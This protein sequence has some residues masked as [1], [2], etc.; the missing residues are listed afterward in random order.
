[1]IPLAPGRF[2]GLTRIGS[3]LFMFVVV[4]PMA[5][6]ACRHPFGEHHLQGAALGTGYHITLYADLD[7]ASL[8]ALET[9]I[10]GELERL[11]RK[12]GLYVRALN[13]A[14]ARVGMPAP[15]VLLGEMDRVVHALA[16]DR[17]TEW[18]DAHEEI[19]A[20]VEMGGVMRA[21]G[22]PPDGGWR[23]SLERA[24]L[25]KRVEERYLYLH[26]AALVHRFTELE[27]S[28][29]IS[30]P[31]PLG[32]SVVADTASEAMRQA[33]R[34]MLARPDDA[35][36]YAERTDRAARLV[37][38]TPQGIVIHQTAALEPWFEK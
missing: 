26:D 18:L 33:N 22:A 11:Q 15:A 4:L 1:M 23:L 19:A 30:L 6:S 9:G 24:G 14:F 17:V 3:A 12:R 36:A 32:V 2:S 37:V 25:P 13:A 21:A 10:Q 35:M 28:P 38:K 34:M 16:V 29:L 27:A 7:D 20:L 8:L 5:L 31:T